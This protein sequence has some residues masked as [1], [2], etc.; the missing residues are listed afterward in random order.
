MLLKDEFFET[1]FCLFVI[2][3]SI[4]FLHSSP[5][6]AEAFILAERDVT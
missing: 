6:A 4:F 2:F 5:F 1:D 3:L